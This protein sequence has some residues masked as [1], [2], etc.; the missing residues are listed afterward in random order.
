MTFG[1]KTNKGIFHMIFCSILINQF[2]SKDFY[3]F[4]VDLFDKYYTE[5]RCT[6]SPMICSWL[7]LRI[8]KTTCLIK[9][10]SNHKHLCVLIWSCV[11]ESLFIFSNK[12]MFNDWLNWLRIVPGNYRSTWLYS[13][14][15]LYF[16]IFL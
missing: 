15:S 9:T 13:V 14:C 8:E 2:C 11:V 1:S 10:V 6:D 5:K 16:N 3:N 7:D 4:C 12:C